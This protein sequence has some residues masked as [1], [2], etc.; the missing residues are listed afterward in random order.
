MG[1]RTRLCC[2]AYTAG[3][4][5]MDYNSPPC[6]SS[7]WAP[8]GLPQRSSA[9]GPAHLSCLVLTRT[10]SSAMAAPSQMRG[11]IGCVG[12][13]ELSG[14]QTEQHLCE[15]CATDAR[16]ALQHILQV[17]VQMAGRVCWDD[18]HTRHRRWWL[19]PQDHLQQMPESLQAAAQPDGRSGMLSSCQNVMPRCCTMS[20]SPNS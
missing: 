7:K 6:N 8:Q 14:H 17:K 13:P 9:R 11:S 12:S 2:T 5:H 20:G 10:S 4:A 19:Q 3:H 15:C 18:L 16:V 1:D